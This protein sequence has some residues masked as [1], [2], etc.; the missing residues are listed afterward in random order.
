MEWTKFFNKDI[1][2]IDESSYLNKINLKNKK[3]Y[4]DVLKNKEKE[5]N[6]ELDKLRV[7]TSNNFDK[8]KY[9]HLNSLKLLEMEKK[10][11]NNINR[12]CMKLNNLDFNF[13]IDVLKYLNGLS[14][15]LKTRLK[16]KD[17][18]Y[19][20]K[21]HIQRCSY[22]FCKFKENCSYNYSNKKNICYQDH[23]VHNMI[24]CDLKQ[25]INFLEKNKDNP[26]KNLN[27]FSKSINTI[28][29]VIN[30]M[31]KELNTRC[32]YH[33]TDEDIEKE[34]VCKSK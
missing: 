34:H 27:D 19:H 28:S 29:F 8:N 13:I 30:H 33:K 16:Q 24:N 7:L 20:N 12:Y 17:I 4:L 14:S 5:F 21:D 10:I 25:I 32:L 15:I 11:I 22:K 6:T 1:L 31:Y 23:Y 18:K 2:I 26:K 3:N 9:N